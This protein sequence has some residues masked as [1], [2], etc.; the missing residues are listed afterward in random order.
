MSTLT[1]RDYRGPFG[2]VVDWLEAPWTVLRPITG[3]PIRVENYVED[4][5]YV[6]KAEL[7]G[8]DPDKDLEVTVSGGILTIK[9]ERREES[10]GKHH[11]EFHYGTFSRSMALPAGADEDHIEALYGHG[12]LEVT[13]KL[14]AKGAD[15]SGRKIP[16][17]QDQH[18]KPA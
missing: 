15:K 13:V 10:N 1:R 4:G 3:H 5:K 14:A 16:V 2:D 7:P 12:I 17:R 11:S 18:I 8:V 9:A 6:V